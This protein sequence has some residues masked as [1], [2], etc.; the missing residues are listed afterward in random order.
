MNAIA[1]KLLNSINFIS[2]NYIM[3]K[4]HILSFILV[5]LGSI[6]NSYAEGTVIDYM[7]SVGKIYSVVVV[8]VIVL[9]GIAFYMIRL[10]RKIS[11]LEK[12]IND[13]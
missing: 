7:Q 5:I 11:K 2:S 9:L 1:T 4:K 8:L 3:K 10:D 12:Q 6:T 13:E